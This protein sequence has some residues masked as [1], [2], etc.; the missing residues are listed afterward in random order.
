MAPPVLSSTLLLTGLLTVGLI[1][2]IRASTK[3]RIQTAQFTSQQT[4]SDLYQTVAHHLQSRAYR[5]KADATSERE[6]VTLVGFV[7]PSLFLAVFLTGLAAIGW[8]CLALVLSTLF[9]EWRGLFWGLLGLSPLAGLF[10]WRRSARPEE[11]SF[12][13]SPADDLSSAQSSL[14]V[15]GHRDEIAQLQAE[16]PL[17]EQA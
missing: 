9:S 11:I 10:Y 3:D 13:V 12:R 14:K 2:F 8:L 15:K 1:F 17:I 7:R 6:T 4:P 5:L 16:L